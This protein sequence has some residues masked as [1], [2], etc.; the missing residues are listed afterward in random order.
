[1]EFPD[2][3]QVKEKHNGL[4]TCIR[5]LMDNDSRIAETSLYLYTYSSDNYLL[6]LGC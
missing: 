6:S 5:Y 4:L 3:V 2:W 1:M